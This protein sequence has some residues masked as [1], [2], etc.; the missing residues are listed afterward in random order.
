MVDGEGVTV[1]DAWSGVV[2]VGSLRSLSKN[3]LK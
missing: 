3:I 2:G 1:K